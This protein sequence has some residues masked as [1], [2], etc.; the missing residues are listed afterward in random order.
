MSASRYV[1]TYK[2]TLTESELLAV[3]FA[4][5]VANDKNR[6]DGVNVDSAPATSIAG[7]Q[8]DL[9]RR[10]DAIYLGNRLGSD[11]FDIVMVP[12]AV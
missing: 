3:M 1:P 6:A 11:K 2:A 10:V 7:D 4:L 12:A 8:R 5:R 9:L